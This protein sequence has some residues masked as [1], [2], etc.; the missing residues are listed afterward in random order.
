MELSCHYT[1]NNQMERTSVPPFFWVIC[2]NTQQAEF[3]WGIKN[4]T[5]AASICEKKNFMKKNLMCFFSP[6]KS[7]D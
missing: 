1:N 2:V 4:S 5:F 3:L 7:K 6:A